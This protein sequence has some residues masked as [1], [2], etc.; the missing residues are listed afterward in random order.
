MSELN[1]LTA[2]N[3]SI[4]F[5]SAGVGDRI[6]ATILDSI[7]MIAYVFLYVI[8]LTTGFSGSENVDSFYITMGVIFLIPVVFYHLLAEYFFNGQSLGK[9]IMKIR[10]IKLDGTE[11]GIG[12]YLLRWLLRI[13]D[14]QMFSGLVAVIAVAAS[15]KGQ[16][17]GDMA[18]GTTVIRQK[19]FV[20]IESLRPV[21]VSADHTVTFPEVER[22]SDKD[23]HTI[24]MV[25]QR[26]QEN[27]NYEMVEHT[28]AKLKENL[29]INDVRGLSD[30]DFLKTILADFAHIS[31]F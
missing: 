25:L 13:V 30:V 29:R 24:K 23:I 12:A 14:I 2:Q 11:P 19:P 5:E 27:D 10:V 31:H 8:I 21:H 26:W 3:V 7:F 28:A 15:D 6:A 18:A 20:P 22:L 1:I 4:E 17:L 16:R 9:K